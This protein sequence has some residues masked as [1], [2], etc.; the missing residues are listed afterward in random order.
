MRS[1]LLLLL[2]AMIPWY[3][4]AA[5]ALELPKGVLSLSQT[6]SFGFAVSEFNPDGE[7]VEIRTPGIGGK[8]YFDLVLSRLPYVNLYAEFIRYFPISQG[9]RIGAGIPL[10]SYLRIFK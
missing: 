9:T 1:F 6:P 5:D 4:F 2:I 8:A 10:R 3:S 7:K